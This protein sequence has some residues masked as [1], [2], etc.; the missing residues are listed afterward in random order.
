M[1]FSLTTS[2]SKVALAAAIFI[3]YLLLDKVGYD[4]TLGRANTPE[5]LEGLTLTF[6]AGPILFLGL[7][8][9]SMIGYSLTAEKAAETRR[10]LDARDAELRAAAAAG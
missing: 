7:G 5:A 2:T 9:A 1:L 6:L 10:Q 4:A 3:T 8:A